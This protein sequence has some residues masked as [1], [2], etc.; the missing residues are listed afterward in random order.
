[1]MYNKSSIIDLKPANELFVISYT[2]LAGQ[3]LDGKI[4]I[5]YTGAHFNGI[6]KALHKKVNKKPCMWSLRIG[7]EKWVISRFSEE[8]TNPLN[9][10]FEEYVEKYRRH[11]KRAEILDEEGEYYIPDTCEYKTAE[12]EANALIIAYRKYY[13]SKKRLIAKMEKYEDGYLVKLNKK[14]ARKPAK[15]A[16]ATT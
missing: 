11:K 15:I 12:E 14:N 9:K 1:M 13:N 2:K 6:W 16:H 4:V 8:K 7:K 10:D 3:I 5:I